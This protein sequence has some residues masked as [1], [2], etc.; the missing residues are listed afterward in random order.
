[1]WDCLCEVYRGETTKTDPSFV[2]FKYVDRYQN[3]V[4]DKAKLVLLQLI[5]VE[6]SVYP[7]IE[8]TKYIEFIDGSIV[9]VWAK[10]FQEI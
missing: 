7:K 8:H 9:L 1:M 3:T 5:E 6:N 4:M 2:L 10:R